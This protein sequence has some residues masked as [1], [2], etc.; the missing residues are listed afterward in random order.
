M[1]SFIPLSQSSLQAAAAAMPALIQR[2]HMEYNDNPELKRAAEKIAGG[3]GRAWKR[4]KSSIRRSDRVNVRNPNPNLQRCHV[5]STLTGQVP[6]SLQSFQIGTSI[7]QGLKLNQ[8]LGQSIHMKGLHVEYEFR[9]NSTSSTQWVRCLIVKQL[10]TVTTQY[11]DMFRGETSSQGIDYNISAA[12]HRQITHPINSKKYKVLKDF[13]RKVLPDVVQSQGR[14]HQI[15]TFFMSLPVTLT[16]ETQTVSGNEITTRPN[17]QVLWFVQN[18]ND[19]T[20][21]T[22]ETRFQFWEYYHNKR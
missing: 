20:N 11:S 17:Y 19:M 16:Y 6:N 13:T 9:N 10:D 4:R 1:A 3:I 18:D 21:I 12:D 15:G 8:R 14:Q 22:M 5:N 7:V 2:A